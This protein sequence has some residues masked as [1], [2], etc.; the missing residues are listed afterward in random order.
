MSKTG[1]S[2]LAKLAL[3]LSG[4]YL[5]CV[6]LMMISNVVAFGRFTI[7]SYLYEALDI[8]ASCYLII[9]IISD[10]E[11]RY[12][13]IGVAPLLMG[14]SRIITLI[15]A[16]IGIGL[17]N[18]GRDYYF[19]WGIGLL[20]GGVLIL[21]AL[22]YFLEPVSPKITATLY[23]VPVILFNINK[24]GLVLSRSAIGGLPLRLRLLQLSSRLYTMK[25]ILLIA[26]LVMLTLSDVFIFKKA[27]NNPKINSKK[28]TALAGRPLFAS[29]KSLLI[30]L[31]IL[32]LVA[33]TVFVIYIFANEGIDFDFFTTGLIIIYIGELLIFVSIIRRVNKPYTAKDLTVYPVFMAVHHL[34]IGAVLIETFSDWGEGLFEMMLPLVIYGISFIP[35]VL[36]VVFLDASLLSEFKKTT[37]RKL[38]VL[39]V[40]IYHIGMAICII[41]S[42]LP[43]YISYGDRFIGKFTLVCYVFRGLS[44]SAMIWYS[45]PND[46][47]NFNVKEKGE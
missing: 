13:A 32:S 41:V 40:M 31:N 28:P 44:L 30:S 21:I 20:K 10:N 45:N 6:L 18:A 9:L 27:K 15:P 11:K 23:L 26:A 12:S 39:V 4:L 25:G 34:F 24:E 43:T 19:L 33:Y 1:R 38:N 8:A 29:Q 36:V 37:I 3:S 7:T 17:Q 46:N 5:A 2:L 14:V 35:T 42:D 22:M 16:V 47:V